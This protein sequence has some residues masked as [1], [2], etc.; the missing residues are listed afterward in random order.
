MTVW[1][2]AWQVQLSEVHR[3]IV[4][5]SRSSGTEGSVTELEPSPTDEKHTSLKQTQSS[6]ASVSEEAPVV[7]KVAG[8]MSRQHLVYQLQSC[9]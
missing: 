2:A 5:D 6:W 8:N 9:K 3:Q 7:S 1:T 4:P